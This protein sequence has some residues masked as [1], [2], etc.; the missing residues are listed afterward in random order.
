MKK[1]INLTIPADVVEILVKAREVDED[2]DFSMY[3]T[4]QG[5]VS[6]C[7]LVGYWDDGN[8]HDRSEQET[9]TLVRKWWEKAKLEVAFDEEVLKAKEDLEK[10]QKVLDTLEQKAKKKGWQFWR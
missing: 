6:F 8:Y 9:W 7:D 2:F 5:K 3:I 1:E 4:K 10:A